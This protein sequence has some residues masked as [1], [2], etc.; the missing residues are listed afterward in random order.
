MS[1]YLAPNLKFKE[2]VCKCANHK[3]KIEKFM[4][5]RD[6]GQPCWSTLGNKAEDWDPKLTEAWIK[7]RELIGRPITINSGARCEAYNNYIYLKDGQTPTKSQ[8]LVCK[9]LDMLKVKGFSIDQMAELAVDAGFT[10]VGK[11]AWGIHV[12]VRQNKARWDYR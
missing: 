10:G 9:A 1:E 3:E 6:I 2:V 12:D 4:K 5:T 8:H 7:F 11:Y